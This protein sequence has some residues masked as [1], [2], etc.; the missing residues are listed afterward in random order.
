MVKRSATPVNEFSVNSLAPLGA[1]GLYINDFLPPLAGLGDVSWLLQGF[2]SASP[3]YTPAYALV[4]PS[5][6]FPRQ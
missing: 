5:G 6:A 3:R 1:T 4:A 2:H